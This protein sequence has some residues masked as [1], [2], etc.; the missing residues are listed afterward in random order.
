MHEH[1]LGVRA[2][3]LRPQPATARE[4]AGE[5]QRPRRRLAQRRDVGAAAETQVRW[6]Q[7]ELVAQL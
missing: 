2:E 3:D 1:E 5:A 4:R 7:P 6:A